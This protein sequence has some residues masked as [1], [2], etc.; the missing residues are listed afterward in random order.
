VSHYKEIKLREIKEQRFEV[1]AAQKQNLDLGLYSN[2]LKKVFELFPKDQIMVMVLEDVKRNPEKV[3]ESI[4]RFVS[5]DPEYKPDTKPQNVTPKI[6]FR[7]LNKVKNLFFDLPIYAG[8]TI[9]TRRMVERLS[10]S[11][12]MKVHNL[13]RKKISL[14]LVDKSKRFSISGSKK[15][16]LMSYYASDIKKVKKLTGLDLSVWYK[17]KAM[18]KDE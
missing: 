2:E 13:L 11:Q 9:L 10:K 16:E 6:R 4:Y 14:M 8:K 15:K 3:A 18:E 12:L 1:F 7:R 17:D 5:V